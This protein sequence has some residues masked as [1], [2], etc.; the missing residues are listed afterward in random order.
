MSKQA[1]LRR[2]RLDESF[3]AEQLSS[4]LTACAANPN[5]PDALRSMKQICQRVARF[6]EG[7][8]EDAEKEKQTAEQRR[9]YKREWQRT[10][11]QTNPEYRE[12]VLQSIKRSNARKQEAKRASQEPQRPAM[13]A[14]ER[15]RSDPEYRAMVRERSK[16]R[17]HR[18]K[19]EAAAS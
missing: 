16:A 2:L 18:L 12:R 19:A 3:R 17:Y 5:D 4:A 1:Y 9:A 13:S 11:Y 14:A 10:Q 7:K 15:Y 6:I 8:P